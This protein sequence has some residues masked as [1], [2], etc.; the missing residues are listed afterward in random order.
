MKIKDYFS[1][2][3]LVDEEVYSI[4]GESAWKFLDDR[5]LECLLVVRECLNNSII[6]NDWSFGGSMQQRG[7]R[8][9]KSSMVRHKENI[10][11]SAHMLGKAVDFDVQG[12]NSSDV[13]KWIEDNA[14][15]F[16]CKVRLENKL[17]GKPISWVHLDV[18]Q[19][20]KNPKVYLFNV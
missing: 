19:E 3:E 20:E 15:L 4:H 2:K 17:N 12:V 5:L 9:N 14:D 8:H 1:I 10:Y 6:I 16:P 13:R 18:I 11:L 7:L